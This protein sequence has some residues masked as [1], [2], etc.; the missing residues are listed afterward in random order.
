MFQPQPPAYTDVRYR[1][2]SQLVHVPHTWIRL[3]QTCCSQPD[4]QHPFIAT[5]RHKVTKRGP[6]PHANKVTA[7]GVGP[8]LQTH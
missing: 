8:P 2:G 4:C 5:L 1:S 6:P 7:Q 3:C